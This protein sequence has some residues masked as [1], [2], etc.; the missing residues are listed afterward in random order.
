MV[1]GFIL[2]ET[3]DL[4]YNMGLMTYNGSAYMYKWYYG[5]ENEETKKEKELEE[6]RLRLAILEKKLL[7]NGP[8]EDHKGTE[9]GKKKHKT[10]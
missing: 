7:T 2:Y 6:L 10:N 1:L 5:I 9:N 4:V 3:V 8:R